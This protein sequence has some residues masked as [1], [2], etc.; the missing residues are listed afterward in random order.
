MPEGFYGGAVNYSGIGKL[1]VRSYLAGGALPVEDALVRIRS[2]DEEIRGI[3][4]SL[5]TNESGVTPVISL[6][7]PAAEYSLSPKAK[8]RPYALYDVEVIKDGYYTKNVEGV[9]VFDTVTT[10]VPVNM[11]LTV[12]SG[13]PM[14]TLDASSP[15]NPNLE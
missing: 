9:A 14:D 6:P 12:G 8:E 2:A 4:Y 15:E 3:E 5:L 1:V 10:I 13:A 7:A 11:I